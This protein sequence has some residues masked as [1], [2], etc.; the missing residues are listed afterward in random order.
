MVTAE[1]SPYQ[2]AGVLSS[3]SQMSASA[4]KR[5]YV[6]GSLAHRAG[7]AVAC[8]SAWQVVVS[9]ATVGHARYGHPLRFYIRPHFRKCRA[10]VPLKLHLV[11]RT[12]ARPHGFPK[13]ALCKVAFAGD[14]RSVVGAPRSHSR[15]TRRRLHALVVCQHL[16]IS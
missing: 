11:P 1:Y 4:L 12:A 16:C 3:A 15:P 5:R 8:G 6:V 9:V 2:A 13:R 10:V 14:G 7:S